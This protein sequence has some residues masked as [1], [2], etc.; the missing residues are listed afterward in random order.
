VNI[1]KPHRKLAILSALLEGCSIRATSRM[2]GAHI[3]TIL[4]VL[5]ETGQ[6]C[7]AVFDQHI[8]GLRCEAVELDELWSFVFKKQSR[9]TPEDRVAHPEYGD[10]YTFVALDP[11]SKM[12]VAFLVG[13][14]NQVHTDRFI[15]NLS[16]RIDGDVQLSTDG[17]GPYIAAIQRHFGYRATHAE[18]VKTYA[19]VNPGR[20]R[21][22]PPKV[23]GVQ[24][25]ER[26][27]IPDHSKVC[28]SYVERNNWTIRCQIRRF[29]RLVNGF[30]RKIENLTA[31]VALW[32]AYYNFCRIHG[33]LRV[34][35]AM[36]AGITNAAWELKE[37]AAL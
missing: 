27:G 7:Q 29:T 13:K 23:T 14:R 16:Q 6:K 4:K 19:V 24:I 10:T 8:H 30:S 5:L 1:L 26:W 36:E 28:T 22:A 15:A 9:L 11:S 21:Y 33:S 12:V 20:G 32:F 37:L 3:E 34:T 35:P 18:L 31:A 2:T 17:Y 25:Y